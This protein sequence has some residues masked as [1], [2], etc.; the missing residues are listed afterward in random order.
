MKF[1]WI[2]YLKIYYSKF[3]NLQFYLKTIAS[4]HCWIAFRTFQSYKFVSMAL[5]PSFTIKWHSPLNL[6]RQDTF[7]ELF[8]SIVKSRLTSVKQMLTSGK[9]VKT[10]Q[11]SN[12]WIGLESNC[13]L[14]KLT[15]SNTHNAIKRKYFKT[16]ILKYA[17]HSTESLRHIN[18]YLNKINFS[19]K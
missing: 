10:I 6:N 7:R 19:F 12:D 1:L 13:R 11:Q 14:K 15:D 4:K 9:S 2:A 5:N 8:I 16:T 18:I 3:L 17:I